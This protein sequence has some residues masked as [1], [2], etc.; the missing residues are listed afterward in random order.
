LTGPFGPTGPTG[1]GPTGP[2][3]GGLTVGS[4]NIS[5]PIGGTFGTGATSIANT[6][7]V[8]LRDFYADSTSGIL[9]NGPAVQSIYFTTPSATQQV[10]IGVYPA[11]TSALLRYTITYVSQS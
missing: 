11:Q 2:T 6:R 3:G 4:V 8:W 7:T 1:L 10:N 5:F 9:S